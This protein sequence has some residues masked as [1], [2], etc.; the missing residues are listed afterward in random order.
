M[1]EL[2]RADAADEP[3]VRTRPL[4]EQ[5]RRLIAAHHGEW[6]GPLFEIAAGYYELRRGFVEHVAIMQD[7]IEAV[8]LRAAA[9]LLREVAIPVEHV[10]ELHALGRALALSH[11]S[12]D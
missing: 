1:C 10:G 9:P 8:R 5:V 12:L 3:P 6:L 7:D 11:V 4:R 2:A